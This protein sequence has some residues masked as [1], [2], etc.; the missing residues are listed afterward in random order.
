[1]TSPEHDLDELL[2]SVDDDRLMPPDGAFERIVGRAQRRK[3]A[4]AALAVLS[5]AVVVAGAVPAVLAVR[6]TSSDQTVAIATNGSDSPHPRSSTLTAPPVTRPI[7]GLVGYFPRSVSFVS[8]RDGFLWG[9]VAGSRPATTAAHGVVAVTHDGGATWTPAGGPPVSAVAEPQ[10]RFASPA[11][12]VVFGGSQPYVTTDGGS[13]WHRYAVPGHLS[14]LEAMNQRIWA[15]VRPSAG[16]SVVRLYGASVAAPKLRRVGAVPAMTGRRGG[17]DGATGAAA[18]ALSGRSVSVLVG[19]DAF[20]TSP[21]AKRW[22]RGHNP[23]PK[24]LGGRPVVPA[25]TLLAA[26][27]SSS[28]VAACGYGARN[29]VQTKLVYESSSAGKRWSP[30]SR[31]PTGGYLETITAG[32]RTIIIGNSRGGAVLTRNNGHTWQ[33]DPANHVDLSFVGFIDTSHVVAVADRADEEVGAFASSTD[34]AR[35]WSVVP[36]PCAKSCP[37]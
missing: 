37:N 32:S 17:T 34:G 14:E 6:D 10:I 29:G 31:P 8:Q 20:W 5:V 7:P 18:I 16:A 4:K 22:T 2:R 27:S 26:G 3:A 30:A 21:N 35:Q 23:C 13:T 24:T 12:G 15:L 33:P 25:S 36:F 19:D 28:L 11:V 1:M 9:T